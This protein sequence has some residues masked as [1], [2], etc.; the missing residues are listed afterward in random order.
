ML[1]NVDRGNFSQLHCCHYLR[2]LL[3]DITAIHSVVELKGAG[4]RYIS[5][6]LA[7]ERMV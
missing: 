2:T 6:R 5:R 3:G 7:A 4:S 1:L